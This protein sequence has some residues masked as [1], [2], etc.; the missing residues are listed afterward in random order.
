MNSPNLSL[1]SSRDYH[2]FIHHHQEFTLII[3]YV[4]LI[5]LI[6][7]ENFSHMFLEISNRN[8]KQICS[9]SCKIENFN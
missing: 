2:F 3:F 7:V 6:L 9:L 5:E 4:D 1:A 8:V